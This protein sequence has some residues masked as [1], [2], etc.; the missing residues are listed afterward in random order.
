[1]FEALEN[2]EL[3]NAIVSEAT[4]A[5]YIGLIANKVSDFN[6]KNCQFKASEQRMGDLFQAL[7]SNDSLGKLCIEN[8]DQYQ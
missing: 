4:I 7:C 6:I 1:M 5:N 8:C 3:S 2:F